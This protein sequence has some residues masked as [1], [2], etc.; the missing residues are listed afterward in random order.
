MSERVSRTE[1]EWR[2]L[3]TPER[4][5]VLRRA[6]TEPPFSGAFNFEKATGMYVC[7]ACG[8]E[9]FD[10]ASKFESGS[11]WP[12]FTEPV[13]AGRLQLIEDRTHGMLRTEVRCGRC[14]SHLGHVFPD[15]PEPTGQRYCINSLALDLAPADA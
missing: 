10:S 4:Y 15:G 2:E 1:E 14:G 12:S 7:G 9:L 3:L 13:D 8:A 6:G 11:G 5:D